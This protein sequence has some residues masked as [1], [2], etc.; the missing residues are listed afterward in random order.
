MSITD[1]VEE[2]LRELNLTI[3][4]YRLVCQRLLA[5]QVIYCD[6]SNTEREIYYLFVRLEELVIET[7]D[8]QGW[9]IYHDDQNCYVMLLAPGANSPHLESDDVNEVAAMRRRLSA[10]DICLLLLLNQSYQQ[11]L[12]AGGIDENGCAN[13]SIE[14]LNQAFRTF[15]GRSAPVGTIR[16]DMF[17]MANSLRVIDARQEQWEQVDGWIKVRPVITSFVFSDIINAVESELP[18]EDFEEEFLDEDSDTKLIQ[19]G[20]TE[21]NSEG[22]GD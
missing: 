5:N 19:A 20:S 13:V 7:M 8:L 11:A 21:L 3:E 2:R 18:E 17:R 16:N 4:D 6:Q 12:L 10:D 14:Q 15:L 9:R 22:V 1:I